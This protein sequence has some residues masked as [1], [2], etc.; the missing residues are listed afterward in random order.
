MKLE[1]GTTIPVG[2]THQSQKLG[3]DKHAFQRLMLLNITQKP[4]FKIESFKQGAWEKHIPKL[5]T[6]AHCAKDKMSEHF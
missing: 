3:R 5:N 2:L 1:F 4:K 6:L